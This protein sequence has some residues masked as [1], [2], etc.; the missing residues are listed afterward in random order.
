MFGKKS[1][2]SSQNSKTEKNGKKQEPIP[3]I[4]GMGD[5]YH[6]YH[7]TVMDRLKAAGIGIALGVA[8]GYVF[9]KIW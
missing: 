1:R 4:M 8:V 7:M 9:L 5:D 3:G 2:K 6:I